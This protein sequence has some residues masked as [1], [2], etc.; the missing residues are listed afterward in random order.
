MADT[1]RVVVVTGLSGAGK[2]SA[3]RML[4]D[5]GFEAIDNLP[6]RL[7]GQLLPGSGG[8]QRP[9]AVGIDARTEG[10]DPQAVRAWI[11]D[12]R[13]RPDIAPTLLYMDCDAEVLARRFTETRRRHPLALDRP[14]PDGIVRERALIGPLRDEA[15]L[16]LETTDF[17]LTDLRREIAE[18]FETAGA[19]GLLVSLLSFSYKGGLPRE[20]DMV[21]DVRFLD[22]PHW[23]AHLRPLTGLD[24]GVA[25]HVSADPAFAD[26]FGRLTGLIDLLVPRFR[27]EGKSYLTLAIGCTGGRHRSVFVAER[28]AAHL[29]EADVPVV[30]RHR[31]L[32]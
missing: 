5:I 30:L 17:S 13:A 10:F 28:L 29:R 14:V 8:A 23:V 12:L 18:R 20:A 32:P 25:A 4:E 27:A 19:T 15:D 11:E 3:L 16:V 24:A 22:N 21:F 2:T 31:E 26:F 7:L 9:I 1:L 6:V